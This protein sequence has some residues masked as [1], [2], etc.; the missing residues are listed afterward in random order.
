MVVER[1]RGHSGEGEGEK[2][3]NGKRE[4]KKKNEMKKRKEGRE[5]LVCSVVSVGS[6]ILGGIVLNVNM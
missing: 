5:D 3:A 1:K 4:T 2:K 6:F